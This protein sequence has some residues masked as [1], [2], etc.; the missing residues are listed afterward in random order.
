MS[1]EYEIKL[2]IKEDYMFKKVFGDRDDNPILISFLNAVLNKK[3]LI[4]SVKMLNTELARD[5]SDTKT[6]VLDIQAQLQ[7][8]TY[9]DIELQKSYAVDLLNRFLLYG[10]KQLCKHTSK[11]KDAPPLNK[12]PKVISI[13]I[14]DCKVKGL[15]I[16]QEDLPIGNFCYTTDRDPLKK[17]ITPNFTIIPIELPKIKKYKNITPELI[18]WL[19]FFKSSQDVSN[20]IEIEE[21]HE[22]Y[23]KMKS[24]GGNKVYINYLEAREKYERDRY[25]ELYCAREEGIKE[26]KKEGI[27]EGKI[28][29]QKQIALNMKTQ[30]LDDEFIA[31]CLNVSI[32]E[33]Q[34]LL[35]DNTDKY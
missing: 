1:I 2:D 31:K 11:G 13:W 14:L 7:D 21:I 33:L 28:E 29:E 25:S 24:I 27:Q 20:P 4:T 15:E 19:Q 35:L 16:F 3:P 5:F 18:S 32:N 34:K 30:G 9:L 26:G 6:V 12:E 8:G 23:E 22:A 10:A 17:V